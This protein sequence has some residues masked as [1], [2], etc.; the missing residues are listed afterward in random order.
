MNKDY[1]I[2]WDKFKLNKP[3]IEY[4][5]EIPYAESPKNSVALFWVSRNIIYIKHQYKNNKAVIIH[6]Y[7]HWLFVQ[8]Y[9]ILDELWEVLWWYFK[10]RNLF[11][12]H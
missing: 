9:Y 2:Q 10:V 11:V 4:V 5:N 6:E 8:T 1:Q 7:G 12:K 3:K